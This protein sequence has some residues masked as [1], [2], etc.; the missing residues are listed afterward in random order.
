M[1]IQKP[2]TT[3]TGTKFV[4]NILRKIKSKQK[5][6]MKKERIK[7]KRKERNAKMECVAIQLAD[8]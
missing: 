7:R 1:V 8:Q 2:K 6:K 3:T 4:F 5:R